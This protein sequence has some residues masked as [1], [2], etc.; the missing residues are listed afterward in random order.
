MI[1]L[2]GYSADEPLFEDARTR[3]WRARHEG[4]DSVLLKE[5][6]GDYPTAAELAAFQREHKIFS[7]L[8]SLGARG[9]ARCHRL[10]QHA[11]SLVL[12]LEDCGGVFVEQ[13]LRQGRLDTRA[14]IA[15]GLAVAGA[16]GSIHA[17]SVI[18]KN[19][20]PGSVLFNPDTG[21]ARLVDFSCATVFQRERTALSSPESL[22]GTLAYISPEQTGRVTSV[23]V[24]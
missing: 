1:S 19:L 13:L 20:T 8:G 2:S 11:N 16:L 22:E 9:A 18:C 6:K 23:K 15:A 14:A 3:C 7:R 4:G 5:L 10:E 24:V 17:A 21:E 12:V